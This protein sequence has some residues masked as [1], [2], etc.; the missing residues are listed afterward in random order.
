[1]KMGIVLVGYRG[2]GKSTVAR[3]LAARLSWPVLDLDAEIERRADRSIADIFAT[4]GEAA[5]RDLEAAALAAALSETG[6]QVIASGGGVI[7]RAANRAALCA[8]DQRVAYLPAPVPVLAARLGGDAGGRPS[9]TGATVADEVA[10]MLARREPWYRE[11]AD[12]TVDAS[13]A[14]QDVAEAIVENL[15]KRFGKSAFAVVPVD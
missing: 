9:L 1:M 12:V 2:C 15:T 4:D 14:P 10:V 5:F 3:R 7:E 13:Q 8:A 11:V 6:P